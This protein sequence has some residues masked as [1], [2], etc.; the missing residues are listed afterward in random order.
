[1]SAH[2]SYLSTPNHLNAETSQRRVVSM[3]SRS[4]RDVSR[5]IGHAEKSCSVFRISTLYDMPRS[6]TEGEKR[7][8]LSKCGIKSGKM[9]HFPY[10]YVKKNCFK[11]FQPGKR[12]IIFPYIQTS[13]GTLQTVNIITRKQRGVS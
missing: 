9:F 3:T 2:K 11:L 7:E 12:N 5:R 6:N 4:R 8:S 13:V 10:Q 1:M